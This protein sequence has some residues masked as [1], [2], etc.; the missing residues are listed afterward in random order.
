MN[1]YLLYITLIILIFIPSNKN[2][3]ILKDNFDI[4]TLLDPKIT[5]L[6]DKL[7]YLQSL[8]RFDSIPLS[9]DN[10]ITSLNN[11]DKLTLYNAYDILNGLDLNKM[12]Q[13]LNSMVNYNY[14]MN[15]SQIIKT[16][17]DI[18]NILNYILNYIPQLTH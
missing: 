14:K 3:K 13:Q 18:I 15:T 8:T 1:D 2:K 7:Q 11:I 5:S 10:I 16:I 6:I 9:I 4:G 12:I 17:N